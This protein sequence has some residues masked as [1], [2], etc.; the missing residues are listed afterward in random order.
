M[1]STQGDFPEGDSFVSTMDEGSNETPGMYANSRREDLLDVS[2]FI[3]TIAGYHAHSYRHDG[4]GFLADLEQEKSDMDDI[5]DELEEIWLELQLFWDLF[6]RMQP[7]CITSDTEYTKQAVDCLLDLS[8]V[9]LLPG[10]R[11]EFEVRGARIHIKTFR[12]RLRRLELL[13]R[14]DMNTCGNSPTMLCGCLVA[15]KRP[16]Y[17]DHL[18]T[19]LFETPTSDQTGRADDRG[20]TVRDVAGLLRLEDYITHVSVKFERLGGLEEACMVNTAIA[21]MDDEIKQCLPDNEYL[22]CYDVRY[23]WLGVLLH[24]TFR[25][26]VV[27]EVKAIVNEALAFRKSHGKFAHREEC[28][29]W[30]PPSPRLRR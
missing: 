23:Q 5:R 22:T 7:N 26:A 3:S 9:R 14:N 2:S 4:A 29:L 6:L 28:E 15:V 13:L 20:F 24:P 1:C 8:L 25:A 21:F 12:R 30:T 19:R 11:P 27:R 17:K 16:K 18:W 10:T